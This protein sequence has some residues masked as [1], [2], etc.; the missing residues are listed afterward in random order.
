MM[1]TNIGNAER[2][3]RGLVGIVFIVVPALLN[4][5]PWAIAIL[6]AAGGSM[7]LE[8]S[9]GYCPMYHKL[10]ISTRRK[11]NLSEKNKAFI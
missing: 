4:W 1:L 9:I 6:A 8:G 2:V 10:G 7:L 11:Q 5:S 3:L